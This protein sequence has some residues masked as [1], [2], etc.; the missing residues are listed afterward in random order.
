MEAST[1]GKAPSQMSKRADT[2][3][4][5]NRSVGKFGNGKMGS[6]VSNF[7][8]RSL[9]SGSVKDPKEDSFDLEDFE[10]IMEKI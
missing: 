7:D 10:D 3:R 8:N 5:T 6:S 1:P 9:K 4:Q 2:L